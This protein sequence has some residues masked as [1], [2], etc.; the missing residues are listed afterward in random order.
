MRSQ[1]HKRI[2]KICSLVIIVFICVLWAELIIH[3]D[4]SS[5][6]LCVIIG[7]SIIAW[8]IIKILFYF[9]RDLYNLPL[10]YNLIS[11][12][13]IV[14]T[15]IMFLIKHGDVLDS[16]C[17]A[18]GVD[19]IVTGLLKAQI[20]I[21]AK[22]ASVKYW[23]LILIFSA[24][25]SIAGLILVFEILNSILAVTLFLCFSLLLHLILYITTAFLTADIIK[26]DKDDASSLKK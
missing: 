20:S 2:A 1:V 16:L 4:F 23:W 12:S 22:S 26:K 5:A 25:T 13:L 24:L 15:G 8:G 7:S 11:G 21:E 10:K 14:G 18:I 17:I 6:F 3:P 19:S 9:S